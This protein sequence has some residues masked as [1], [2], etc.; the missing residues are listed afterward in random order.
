MLVQ[1]RLQTHF[2]ELSGRC[3]EDV[4]CVRTQDIAFSVAALRRISTCYLLLM[5]TKYEEITDMN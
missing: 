5:R 3:E 2:R 1:L 4:Q